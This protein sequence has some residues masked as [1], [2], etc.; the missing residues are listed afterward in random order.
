MYTSSVTE[1]TSDGEGFDPIY[2]LSDC[3]N[4]L[5]DLEDLALDHNQLSELP[6]LNLPNLKVIGLVSNKFT[7]Y[8]SAL[9]QYN[10]IEKRVRR[11]NYLKRK[12][13]KTLAAKKLSK[14]TSDTKVTAKK[15]AT[16]KTAA[17]KAAT[18]KAAT[19][20]AATKKTAAKK[21]ATKKT[22]ANKS[23]EENS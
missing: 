21:A 17:K 3:V 5:Q 20:K 7:S 14:S 2:V 22:A 16:K 23:S 9:K 18:K 13:E 10:K 19:K 8:P 15:A 1:L 12:R 6:D 11:K 4:E